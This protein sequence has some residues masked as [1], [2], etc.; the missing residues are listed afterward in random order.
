MNANE[1]GMRE[2]SSDDLRTIEGGARGDSWF[3]ALA[4]ALGKAADVQGT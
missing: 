3:V 4:I 2:V 1:I